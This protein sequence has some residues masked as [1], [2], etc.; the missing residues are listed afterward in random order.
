LQSG[1][2]IQCYNYTLA[3]TF[4]RTPNIAIG[5]S[6]PHSAISQLQSQYSPNLFFSI[7]V[8]ASSN[9]YTIP[10]IV[11]THWAYT[12]WSKITF[13]FVAEAAR[14]VEAGYFQVD[15]STLSSC[16]SGKE[17]VAF[18]PIR[19]Q[20]AAMTKG[21]TFLNGFE[22]SSLASNASALTPFEV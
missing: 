1:V 16:G 22:I 18:L 10:F 9:L 8:A 6:T 4:S 20:N 19:D 12:R 2:D 5:T 21:M 11:R 14:Q 13:S 15:T 17:I 7:K 3:S